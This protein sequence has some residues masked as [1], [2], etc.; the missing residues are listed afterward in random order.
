MPEALAFLTHPVLGYRLV[1]CAHILTNL[2]GTDAVTVL[3]PVDAQKFG[4]LMTL[5][6][7][8]TPGVR[9]FQE[10]LDQ[11]FGGEP[12]ARHNQPHHPNHRSA[13]GTVRTSS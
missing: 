7:R 1:E 11:Y 10:V 8:T 12:D 3:G 13:N 6:A 4:S 5:L 9:V 2:P